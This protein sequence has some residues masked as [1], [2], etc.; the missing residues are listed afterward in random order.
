MAKPRWRDTETP[1][2]SPKPEQL[3]CLVIKSTPDGYVVGRGVA[4][5]ESIEWL[6]PTHT[7]EWL[8]TRP[9]DITITAEKWANEDGTV[10]L[11]PKRVNKG[12]PV[13]TVVGYQ[14]VFG[15]LFDSAAH[16]AKG[17]LSRQMKAVLQARKTYW[18]HLCSKQLRDG[19]PT[20]APTLHG[21]ACAICGATQDNKKASAA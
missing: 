12:A 4:V 2:P 16:R 15:E 21:E 11:K 18:R 9:K 8:E 6:S 1:P 10:T 5:A 7:R 3:T 13:P 20:W 17:E 14:V 19:L